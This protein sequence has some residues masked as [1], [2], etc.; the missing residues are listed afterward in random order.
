MIDNC[1][2]VNFMKAGNNSAVFYICQT[3]DVQNEFRPA[4]L[5]SQF[6]TRSL[7]I[8]IRQTKSFADLPQTEA[9]DHSFLRR[10]GDKAEGYNEITILLNIRNRSIQ[11]LPLPSVLWTPRRS[12]HGM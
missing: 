10:A 4:S 3:A 6:E 11:N 2:G 7:N 12:D 9:G 5:R 8:A 1:E